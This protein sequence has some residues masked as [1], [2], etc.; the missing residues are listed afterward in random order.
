M[1]LDAPRPR[2]SR[3]RWL[4]LAAVALVALLAA[5]QLGRRPAEEPPARPEAPVAEREPDPSTADDELRRRLE[6]AALVELPETFR[7]DARAVGGAALERVAA[8]VEG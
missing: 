5:L 6:A 1:S 8:L 2:R 4:A 3:T 7:C